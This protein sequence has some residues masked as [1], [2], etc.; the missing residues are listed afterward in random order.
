MH[1]SECRAALAPGRKPAGGRTLK[2]LLLGAHCAGDEAWGR[3]TWPRPGRDPSRG[4]TRLAPASPAEGAALLLGR[5][6]LAAI[7]LWSGFGKLANLG[8]FANSLAH[9]GVPAAWPLA[10][11]GACVEFFGGLADGDVALGPAGRRC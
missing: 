10:V 2:V 3:T 1:P 6:A 7:F 5:L 8:G 11:V 9:Q 4:R